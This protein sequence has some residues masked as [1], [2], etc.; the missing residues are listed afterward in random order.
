MGDYMGFKKEKIFSPV[1]LLLRIIV[2]I[3]LILLQVL[4][5][6]LLF[7]GS[8]NLPYIYL[9]A[10]I[11]SILLVIRLYNSSDNISY[12]IVWII[13]I[14][15]FSL[16]GPL[17]YLCFGNGNNLPKRK[18]KKIGGYLLS[19]IEKNDCLDEIKTSDL[20][21]ARCANYLHNTTGLYPY[22]NQGEEFYS[23]G[24]LMFDAMLEAIDRA[25]KYIF[26]EYFIVASGKML[27]RL[28]EHLSLAKDRGVEIKFI[29]DYVGCNVPKVLMKKDKNKLNEITNDNFVSYNPLGINFNLGINYRDHRKILLID[30][31]ECFVGGINIADEYI[32]E[33]EKYGLWRDNG[34]K[35]VGEAT[36]NY[37]L[38]FA[39]MW[40]MSTKETLDVAKY[41]A[42]CHFENQQGYVFPFAD[43]PM[44][45]IDPAYDLF[46][47]LINNAKEKI[48][49]STPYLVID[50]LFLKAIENQSKSGVE[51]CLLVPEIPDKKIVYMMTENNFT[52]LAKVGV[53]VYKYKGG[54]NHAKTLIVDGKY[55]VIGT[56]NT[57]YRSMFLH[58]ECGNFLINT[59]SVKDIEKDFLET[60]DNSVVV[61][62]EDG[63]KIN[64]F[65][66]MFGFL[67]SLLSP[68][69]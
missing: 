19:L 33:K 9:I 28:I 38:M 8:L 47:K 64:P 62:S 17:L 35:I 3:I 68:L 56:I 42:D 26:M 66:R 13:I 10:F 34:M 41:K 65:K 57:D 1:K 63:K 60:I 69:F 6:F 32:H 23:D 18:N 29:Y 46:L 21:G 24:V 16:T 31:L 2:S 43:G 45:K 30:G 51:V 20:F 44:D 54:F 40:F 5:Y 61:T 37:L 50:N 15:M 12:K 49:I 67:L 14:L 59:P 39:S 4:I 53:K 52:K 22:N 27:D 11:V 7:V 25:Q 36:Y 55:C 48:Y 58:F